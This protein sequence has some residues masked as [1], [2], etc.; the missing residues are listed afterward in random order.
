MKHVILLF[1]ISF[2]IGT[3]ISILNWNYE[4]FEKISEWN[5]IGLFFI[6]GVALECYNCDSAHEDDC[7]DNG[8]NKETKEC[9]VPGTARKK[10]YGIFPVCLKQISVERGERRT[11]RGCSTNGGSIHACTTI[12][13]TIS[14]HCSLCETDYC[15]SSKKH[16]LSFWLITLCLVLVTKIIF[17]QWVPWLVIKNK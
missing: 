9:Q 6:V 2:I 14:E 4:N 7:A 13:G 5:V 12:F 17:I 3:S 16:S 15:N 10:L 11:T 8:Y 1:V